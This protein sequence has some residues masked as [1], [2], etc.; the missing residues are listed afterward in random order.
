VSLGVL[1]IIDADSVDWPSVQ[2]SRPQVTTCSTASKTLSQEVRK[3]SAV[4]FHDSRLAQGAR[5]R[6]FALVSVRLPSPPGTSSTATTPQR[7]QSTRRIVYRRKTRNPH[8]E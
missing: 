8:R 7:R 5:K 4:S 3:A 1:N 6:M 2:C